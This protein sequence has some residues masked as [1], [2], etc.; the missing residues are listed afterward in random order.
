MPSEKDQTHTP[1]RESDTLSN[2]HWFKIS[3]DHHEPCRVRLL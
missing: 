2:K 1:R 3:W